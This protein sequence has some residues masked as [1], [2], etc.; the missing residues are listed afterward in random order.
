M[1]PMLIPTVGETVRCIRDSLADVIAPQLSTQTLRSSMGSTIQL[2]HYVERR[3]ED[4]G[5]MFYDEIKYLRGLFAEVLAFADKRPEMASFAAAIR[6]TL[7][8]KRD[9]DTYP[10]LTLLAQEIG[11]MRQ[12]VC[13]ALLLVQSMSDTESEQLRDALHRYTAWQIVREEK[14]MAAAFRG[15]G[16]R[17]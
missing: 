17:R 14:L 16:P 11:Q 7:D 8:T 9:P 3:V 1:K 12:H 5:Q 13:D 15:R 6:Q 2:L 10:S 4:E